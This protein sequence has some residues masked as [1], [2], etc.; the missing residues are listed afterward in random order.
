VH[1]VAASVETVDDT[2]QG[3]HRKALILPLPDGR[4]N[5]RQLI[6]QGVAV[7][8]D[9]LLPGGGVCRVACVRAGRRSERAGRAAEQILA[10]A[11]AA[12]RR[13]G[14]VATKLLHVGAFGVCDRLRRI[15]GSDLL[16]EP[17]RSTASLL[18]KL[19]LVDD[20]LRLGRA[21]M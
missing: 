6:G 11:A 21:R 19:L 14:R 15:V 20:V 9:F 16:G 2:T 13:A 10:R 7:V 17:L 1:T 18:L 3:V 12:R 5:V 4:V 8:A